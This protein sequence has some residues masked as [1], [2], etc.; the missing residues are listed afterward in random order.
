MLYCSYWGFHIYTCFSN[1]CM[2]VCVLY[3]IVFKNRSNLADF[4]FKQKRDLWQICTDCSWSAL[5]SWAV[6]WCFSLNELSHFG[7][8]P[9]ISIPWRT[10]PSGICTPRITSAGSYWITDSFK[11]WPLL[12]VCCAN[13]GRATAN[14]LAFFPAAR[15]CWSFRMAPAQPLGRSVWTH[16]W[17]CTSSLHLTGKHLDIICPAW[18]LYAPLRSRSL[19]L[20]F[21]PSQLYNLSSECS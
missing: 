15:C 13:A 6:K 4:A 3:C 21:S 7:C 5:L 20:W 16:L 18:R 9:P 12:E 17:S 1:E 14:P 10:M 2:I 19:S 11:C 8:L